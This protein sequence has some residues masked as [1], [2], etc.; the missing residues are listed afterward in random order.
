MVG[1]LRGCPTE[2][3]SAIGEAA[4]AAGI[5]VL[6]VTLDSPTPIESIARLVAALP[7]VVVGAG[8]AARA[9]QRG[10]NVRPHRRG[11]TARAATGR[12]AAAWFITTTSSFASAPG[13]AFCS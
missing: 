10:P 8:R 13:A 4:S 3:V 9:F 2:H 11:R 5:A 12:A 7:A 1:I 6:E